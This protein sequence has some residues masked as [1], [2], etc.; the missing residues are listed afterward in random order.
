MKSIYVDEQL[1]RDLKFLATVER[2]SLAELVESLLE[3][4]L[5]QRLSDLPAAALQQLAQA[6]GSFDFLDHP[7]EDI[8]TDRDGTP[9]L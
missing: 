4:P 2:R 9:V 1:H 6:G 3:R 8:Y 7:A 5:Q